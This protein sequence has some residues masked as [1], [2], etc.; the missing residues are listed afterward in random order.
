[1]NSE[2]EFNLSILADAAVLQPLVES[3]SPNEPP[4]LSSLIASFGN[5]DLLTEEVEDPSWLWSEEVESIFSTPASNSLSKTKRKPKSALTSH[6]ILT[7]QE[8]IDSKRQK[9]AEK[10]EK[11]KRREERRLSKTKRDK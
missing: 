8:I 3:E 7:S 6:R 4:N 1:M 10:E 9:F 5:G 11:E 2:D